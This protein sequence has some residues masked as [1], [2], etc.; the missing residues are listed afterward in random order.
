MKWFKK[1]FNIFPTK[2]RPPVS[3]IGEIGKHRLVHSM[4]DVDFYQKVISKQKPEWEFRYFKFILWEYKKFLYFYKL[5]GNT[6]TIK[7]V[8][9]LWEIH[10]KYVED[11]TF[12]LDCILNVESVNIRIVNDKED[13]F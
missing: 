10:K 12:W 7:D 3:L 11:Y 1:I 8:H 13:L 4:D 6:K 9:S 5:T 2:K